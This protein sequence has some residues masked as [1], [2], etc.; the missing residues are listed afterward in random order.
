MEISNQS[1]T[2]FKTPVITIPREP[3]EYGKR[4]WEEMKATV[5]EIKKNPQGRKPGLYQ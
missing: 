4:I 5:S 3:T 2:D 1:D